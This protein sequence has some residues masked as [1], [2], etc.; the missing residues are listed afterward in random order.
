MKLLH[1]FTNIIKSNFQFGVRIGSAHNNAGPT[2]LKI[3]RNIAFPDVQKRRLFTLR[4]VY[5][6]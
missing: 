3:A 1:Y 2:D 6:L 5:Q 4:T